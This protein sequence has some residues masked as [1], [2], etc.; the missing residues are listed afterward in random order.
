MPTILFESLPKVKQEKII[1]AG[2]EEFSKLSYEQ[3]SINSIIKMA[4]ISRGSFYQYFQDKEDL[5]VYILTTNL[6]I[7]FNL[8]EPILQN[9]KLRIKEKIINIF[10]TLV[11]YEQAKLFT[12]IVVNMNYSHH[13]IILNEISLFMES[14]YLQNCEKKLDKEKLKSVFGLVLYSFGFACF[15]YFINKNPLEEVKETLTTNLEIIEGG[16]RKQ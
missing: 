5:Y 14:K 1:K 2:I 11:S 12:K 16:L 13:K 15:S 3:A 10:E 6:K 7:S 8:M 4:N 9:S